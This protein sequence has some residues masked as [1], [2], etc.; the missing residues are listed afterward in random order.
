MRGSILY[1]R[2]VTMYDSFARDDN[3][4][5]PEDLIFAWHT[6]KIIEKMTLFVHFKD[7]KMNLLFCYN[8]FMMMV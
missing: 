3:M 1:E 5:L 7:W 2:C 4:K 6:I 8:H